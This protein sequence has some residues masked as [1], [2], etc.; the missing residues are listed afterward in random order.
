MTGKS[1]AHS[2]IRGNGEYPL[3]DE[4]FTMAEYLKQNGYHTGMFGKWGLGLAENSGSPEK[5]GWDEFLGY[6]NHVH[7]HHLYTK[8][9]WTIKEGKTIKFPTDSLR[10]SHQYIMD[11]A[12]D[13]IKNNNSKPFFMYLAVTIPHAEVFS[14]SQESL[15]PFLN[16]D[17][18]SVFPE[19]SFIQK[20]GNYRSQTMPKANFAASITHLDSD[21]GKLLGLLKSLGIDDNTYVIFT[22]DNGPHE[23]GGADPEFFD[24]NGQLRGIKRDLY[25]GG[26]R[27]PFIAW[28]GKIKGNVTNND[29]L[30]N[31]DFFPTV[32]ELIGGQKT[33]G[34]EGISFANA[35]KNKPIK[36]KHDFLYWEFY[37]RGFSQ[38]L[39]MGDW[40]AVKIKAKGNKM[41]LYNL[42]NDLGEQNDVANQY[43]EIVQKAE[44]TILENRAD[45][46]IWQIKK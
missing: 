16:T 27:V 10:H 8:N 43:P 22:S 13:F 44:K 39:R 25:E 15:N 33:E 30:A 46:E 19:K 18:S 36:L 6:T 1:M 2:Y 45:S 17:K 21:V 42:K 7:A 40:K 28:G 5:Q 37:E 12:L 35:F 32:Q 29:I 3:R 11:A 26:I 38:A 9:L 4:D 23:E 31:W 41:E 24:S 20:S 34:L 14:P